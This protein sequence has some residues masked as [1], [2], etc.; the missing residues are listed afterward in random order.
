MYL[1][2]GKFNRF[3][4]GHLYSLLNIGENAQNY[5]T[6]SISVFF[7]MSHFSENREIQLKKVCRIHSD[8]FET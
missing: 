6:L 8:G 4:L 7:E 1:H 5:L 3:E 2:G